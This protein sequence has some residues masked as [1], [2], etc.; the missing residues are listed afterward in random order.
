VN[1]NAVDQYI[2]SVVNGNFI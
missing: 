1:D 2:D